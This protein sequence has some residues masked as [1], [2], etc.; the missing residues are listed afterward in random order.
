M[1]I[2]HHSGTSG[3]VAALTRCPSDLKAGGSQADA[4]LTETL[5]TVNTP[6]AAIAAAGNPTHVHYRGEAST[7]ASRAGIAIELRTN[8]RTVAAGF[9]L[10]Q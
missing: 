10:V 9:P 4:D 1:T 3:V 6:P 7:W 2:C 5:R 8:E